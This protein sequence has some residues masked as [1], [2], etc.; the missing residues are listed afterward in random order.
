MGCG[1]SGAL[2][3][4]RIYDRGGFAYIWLRKLRH[5]LF[6]GQ[7]RWPRVGLGTGGK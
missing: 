2:G 4:D 1:V 3:K 7:M 5:N 6:S